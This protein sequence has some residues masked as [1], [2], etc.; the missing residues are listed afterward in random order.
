MPNRKFLEEYPLYRKFRLKLPELL[1]ELPQISINMRC[2]N[3]GSNETFTMPRGYLHPNLESQQPCVGATRE[4]EYFCQSCG[5]YVRYF[6]LEFGKDSEGDY[7]MKVGQ[8]PPWDIDPDV[9]VEKMLGARSDYY[10]RALVCESQSYG[11]GAFAYYR[12]IVEEIIDE[13]LLGITDLVENDE[14]KE[15]YQQALEQTKKT[16]IAQDK[17][18]L[19]KELLPDSLR[20][21]GM[22]PLSL[23]HE[24]L[25][26]GLH[27][28]T[29]NRCMELSS[30]VRGVLEFLVNQTATTKVAKVTFTESMKRLLGRHSDKAEQ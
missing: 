14:Q 11:I 19:V 17:I 1:N 6:M 26:E 8:A 23:L 16:K 27:G 4:V 28:Q 7:V 20:P 24:V 29:D 3:E 25:S 30:D 10:R 15:K 9:A 22:N 12:R 21:G 13:L 2:E 18:A 5:E